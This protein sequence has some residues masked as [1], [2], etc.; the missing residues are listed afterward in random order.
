MEDKKSWLD[1]LH[2]EFDKQKGNLELAYAYLDKEGNPKFSKW[3]KYL[4]TQSDDKFISKVNN[5][6]ILPNEIDLDLEEPERFSEV[7]KDVKKEFKFYSAYKTGSRGYHIRLWFNGKLS[8]DEKRGIIQRYGCDEQKAIERCMIAL[9]NVPHWKTGKNKELIEESFGINDCSPI[10]KEVELKKEFETK[11][12]IIDLLDEKELDVQ[13]LDLGEINGKWYYGFKIKGREAIMTSTGEI[14]RNTEIK[15]KEGNIGENQIKKLFDYKGNIGDIAPIIS[16]ETIKK[17][18]TKKSKTEL[19]NPKETYKAIRDKILYYMDFSGKNEIADVLTCWIIATYCYPLFYWFPH[20]LFNAPSQSGKT[21]GATIVMYLSFRGFDL[22]ASS[23]VTPAQ[24]FRTLEGNRGTFL[25]DEFE[26]AKGTQ[27]SETQ[28]LVNQLLNASASRDAYVIRNEKIKDKW[29]AK[30]FPIFSPKISCNISG[31]N[32][33]SLSRYIP[34]SWLKT[35]SE[36][37]KRKPTREKD[38]QNFIPLREKLYILIL[39]NYSEIK[40]MYEN[41]EIDLSNRDEDNWLPLFSIAKFIDNS[42]GEEVKVEENLMKYVNSYKELSIETND[43]TEDFFRIL[44]ECVT[45][46]ERY[47]TP[48]ELGAYSDI[49]ELFNYLKSPPHKIGKILKSYKFTD[50][51]RAGGTKKY[52]LSKKSV[53]NIIDL[54]FNT[55]PHK[56]TNNT[57]QHKQHTTTQKKEKNVSLGAICGITSEKEINISDIDF[58]ELNLEKSKDE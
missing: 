49:A 20:I 50:N 55:T 34:F 33:T 38:K 1:K 35:D 5:R 43:N 44:L 4:D 11:K 3:K 32:P 31:I 39:E 24:I 29:V 18:Y 56:D 41:L 2:Y 26:Q 28:Q 48:K 23:G 8:P 30:K 54:Y 22:G 45:E 12:E 53:K 17:Y 27:S 13:Y 52:L 36:K 19:I 51:R 21:K 42:E 9:E 25:I 15:T 58:S 57:Q 7:L 40:E 6:T 16:K 10:K 47:Y 14:Y 37:G 46:N